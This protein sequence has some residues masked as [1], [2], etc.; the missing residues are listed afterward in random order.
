MYFV[1][2]NALMMQTWRAD[3]KFYMQVLHLSFA[4]GG[5][6]SPLATAP[7]LLN[8]I[9]NKNV[10]DTF[11]TRSTNVTDMENFTSGVE[12]ISNSSDV[13]GTDNIDLYDFKNGAGNESKLY[14]A[15]IITSCLLLTAAIS[16]LV[17]HL[18]RKG[19]NNEE[20]ANDGILKDS[21]VMAFST[22]I[23]ALVILACLACFDVAIEKGTHE[24]ITTFCVTQFSWS[25]SKGSY[26]NSAFW[27]AYAFGRFSG[28]FTI[29]IIKPSKMI[30]IYMIGLI[31]SYVG[32]LVSAMFDFDIGIWICL[33]LSGFSMSIIFPTLFTWT[34]ISL[35]PVT[36]AVASL[37]VVCGSLGSILNPLAIGTL[38]D[39][40]TAM[41]FCYLLLGESVILFFLFLSALYLSKTLKFQK[42]KEKS[43]TVT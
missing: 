24:F 42:S 9:Q 32:L 41:Y 31:L 29:Q 12:Q 27:A 18:K 33:P 16:F 21:S 1:V 4:V 38:M 35:L 7:F 37:F 23:L 15:Y 20:K 3:N 40:V 36:G 14:Q 28:I 6:L 10:S 26:L 25:K 2:I 8:V 39:N 30:L 13:F 34:E 22:K 17:L 43:L 11:V 19:D 5:I